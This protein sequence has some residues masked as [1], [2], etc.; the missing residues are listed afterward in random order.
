[1]YG[2]FTTRALSSRANAAQ[3]AEAAELFAPQPLEA[4]N[5]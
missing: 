1:L 5:D 4:G 3:R 2:H